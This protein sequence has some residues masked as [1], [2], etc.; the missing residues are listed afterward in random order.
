MYLQ[1]VKCPL[2]A[3]KK[4]EKRKKKKEKK[5]FCMETYSKGAKIMSKSTCYYGYHKKEHS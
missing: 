4:K 3:K 2:I 1:I 5:I